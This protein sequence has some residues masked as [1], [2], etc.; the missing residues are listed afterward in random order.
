MVLKY[1]PSLFQIAIKGFFTFSSYRANTHLVN[2]IE[3]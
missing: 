2:V 1:K 3:K